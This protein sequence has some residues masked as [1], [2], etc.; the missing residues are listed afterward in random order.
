MIPKIRPDK[1]I[2]FQSD[3]RKVR[4]LETKTGFTIKHADHFTGRMHVINETTLP[5]ERV[6]AWCKKELIEKKQGEHIVPLPLR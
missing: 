5:L 4:I 1:N 6:I 2:V 3:D